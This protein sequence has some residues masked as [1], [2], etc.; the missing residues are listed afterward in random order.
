MLRTDAFNVV[1]SSLSG[2]LETA[3]PA[4]ATTALAP[5]LKPS[6]AEFGMARRTP[7]STALTTR[8]AANT[9]KPAAIPWCIAARGI[10]DGPNEANNARVFNGAD[11]LFVTG[12]KRSATRTATFEAIFPTVMIYPTLCAAVN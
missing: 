2:I 3:K 5:S 6:G 11:G 7:A 4:A 8:S 1:S 12:F 10:K 9:D